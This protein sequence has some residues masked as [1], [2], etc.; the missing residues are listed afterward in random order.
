MH[1]ALY[2]AYGC[3][4]CEVRQY[5]ATSACAPSDAKPS[6]H[7]QTVTL[8]CLMQRAR[9][10]CNKVRN[11]TPDKFGAHLCISHTVVLRC[12]P[13]PALH[14]LSTMAGLWLVQILHPVT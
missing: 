12:Q 8:G 7:L 4:N 3:H 11:I 14:R 5:V 2:V 1:Q 13:V 10:S 6:F 9:D